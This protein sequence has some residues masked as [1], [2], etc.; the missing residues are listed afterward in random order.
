MTTIVLIRHCEA[1]GQDPEAPLTPA[2][3]AQAVALA[4]RLAGCGIERIV[5]S[6]YARAV[7]SAAP[8][9]EACGIAVEMDERLVERVLCEGGHPD[10]RGMLAA[11]FDDPRLS[12]PGGESGQ[13]AAARGWAVIDECRERGTATAIVT[14]GNLMALMLQRYDAAF[15]YE[16]WG[17]LTNPDVY[18]LDFSCDPPRVIR[19]W[20][21]C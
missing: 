12:F 20:P 13:A 9:A 2:G 21:A 4:E 19:D 5:S 8:L 15:G 18:R 1:G 7:Q 17:R 11:S 3:F 6:P 14:H 16:G 10:W